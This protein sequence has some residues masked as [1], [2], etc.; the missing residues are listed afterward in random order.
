MTVQCLDSG[1]PNPQPVRYMFGYAEYMP[2]KWI[3]HVDMNCYFASVEQQ[4]NPRLR[5]KPIGV[6]GKPGTRSVIA[7]ASREAKTRGVNTAMSSAE[8]LR[9]CPELIIVEPNYRTYQEYS[10]RLFGLLERISPDLEIFSID[11]AFLDATY[12]LGVPPDSAQAPKALAQAV[13]TIKQLVRDE[14]GDWLTVSV[15]IGHGKRLA[16]LASDSM[17]PDGAVAIVTDDEASDALAFRALGIRSSTRGDF[18]A[19]ADIE[20]LAGIGPR[21]GRRLRAT[22]IH[23]LADLATRSLDE[24]RTVVYP[25]ERELYLIGQG[26][27]PSPLVPYWRSKA[28]QSIGHQYTLPTDVPVIDLAP[29]LAWLAERIGRRLRRGGFVAHGLSLYLRRTDAPGWGSVRRTSAALETDRDIYHAAWSML[30]TEAETPGS[31]LGWTTP[32]RMPSLTVHHL[33]PRQ[34]STQ[35]FLP[36]QRRARAVSQA[37]DRVK[38]QFGNEAIGSGLSVDV[39]HHFVPD[40]RRKRFV[41]HDPHQPS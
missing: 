19:L 36:D 39:H 26:I 7:S 34:S 29:T 3:L 1:K 10:E 27:D 40:G 5:G 25:Y 9:I 31:A 37:I 12:V 21:L 8:A 32:I 23:T 6:G 17:K 16:K 14:L 20:L 35:G 41:P 38:D 22:G 24:L 13:R 15:G 2:R 33:V 18:Y 30:A 28:E 11:E 4:R